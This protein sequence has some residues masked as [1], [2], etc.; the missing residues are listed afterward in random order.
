M[1]IN[2]NVKIKATPFKKIVCIQNCGTSYDICNLRNKFFT[3]L[4]SVCVMN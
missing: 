3:T 2:M 4:Q 1:L